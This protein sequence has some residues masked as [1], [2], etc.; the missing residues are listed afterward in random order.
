MI[1]AFVALL[2]LFSAV[3]L[4]YFFSLNLFYVL[5]TVLS[6]SGL[7]KHQ[8][9]I[10]YV[11]FRDIFRLPVV[12]P[13]SVIVPAYNE[14]K[15]I[16][17]S[18]R[19]FLSLEYPV[20]EV[21]VVNDGS[22]DATLEKLIR[23]FRLEKSKRVFRRVLKTEN[24]RG[25][26]LSPD[27]PRLV[28]V[29]KENG[30]KADAL[31]AGLNVSRYPLFC[32]VD[33]DS[34][35]ERDALLKM[36]RPFLEDPERVVA[37]GGVIRLSNGC[38]VEGG[39][40]RQIRLPR[41]ALARFQIVEYLRAFFGGRM[42]LSMLRSLLIISG[43]FGAFRKDVVLECGGYRRG[44]VGEDVDLVVR[45]VRYLREKKRTFTIRFVPDP[46]CW[47]EAPETMKILSR[48]RNRWHRGLIETVAYNRK[49]LF[50]PR[51][52]LTGMFA[53][54]FYF[55]YEMLGPVI[56]VTG[57]AFLVASALLGILNYPFALLFFLL[58]IFM[59]VIV[60]L[61]SVLISEYSWHRYPRLSDVL[62]IILF[63]FLENFF[64]RQYLALVRA[65]AFVDY[66]RGVRTWGEMTRK[67]FYGVK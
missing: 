57:Y 45:L 1:K 54:P 62:N 49:M 21:I 6:L 47:T 60:S 15:T 33:S 3:V 8:R 18:V 20:Y 5:F 51:Y 36:V 41:N 56:E 39:Q 27:E 11:T 38:R 16:I 44:T 28:V 17:E 30:G 55:I 32:A 61:M 34:L 7:I 12:K 59:G 40:V 10:T 66:F 25:I 35:L 43:A 58:A 9:N 53:L 48:Q 63:S 37:A 22:K 4:L 14:E 13:F 31:N 42:G 2:T 26:Y 46:I 65:R 67:G 19:S 52:G 23:H 64:Y 50:N 24:I 29:D